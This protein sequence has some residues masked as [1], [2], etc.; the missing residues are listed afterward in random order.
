MQLIQRIYPIVNNY[1]ITYGIYGAFFGLSV[2]FATDEE[3]TPKK[4]TEHLLYY[5]ACGYLWPATMPIFLYYKT[6]EK[7][8]NS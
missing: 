4:S 2:G 3:S 6:K 1:T 7:L 5:T 8:I